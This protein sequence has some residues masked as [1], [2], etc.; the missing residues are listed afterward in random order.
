MMQMM[1]KK[2]RDAR[3]IDEMGS[4]THL[5]NCPHDDFTLE[6]PEGAEGFD[7]TYDLMV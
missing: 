6:L 2:Q 7:K 4:L 3:L 1:G 5:S